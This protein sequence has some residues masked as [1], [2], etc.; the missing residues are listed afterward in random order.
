MN[1]KKYFAAREGIIL[2]ESKSA[3]QCIGIEG[4][5][6]MKTII[7]ILA[8][9]AFAQFSTPASGQSL[10]P[11][12]YKF[13]TVA[14]KSDTQH[15]KSESVAVD[16][17][18]NIYFADSKQQVICRVNPSGAVNII[19]GKT[20]TCGSSDGVG[21]EARFRYPHGIAIDT[22]GN[23]YVADS[24]N[25]TIRRI[26]PDGLVSTIAGLAGAAGS[27]DGAGMDARFRYPIGVA[28]D[29]LRNIYVADVYNGTIRKINA[30][31]VVSTIAG[32]AG[33]LGAADGRGNYPRFNLPISLAV[34]GSG[35][36]YVADMLNN[37][38]RKISWTGTVITWAGTMSYVSGYADGF[39]KGARFSHPCGIAVDKSGNIYVA[40]SGNNTIRRISPD[41]VVTTLAG[42]SGQRGCVD[43]TG[44]AAR[45][46]HPT[47]LA[48]DRLGNLYVTDR[49][50]GAIRE[51][52]APIS[53]NAALSLKTPVATNTSYLK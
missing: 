16:T 7:L 50:N 53:A 52:S 42:V 33:I 39:G 45:F 12:P 49:D 11:S 8:C 3:T 22:T 9:L 38:I 35:N 14:G 26:T 51:G 10:Y 5:F 30:R 48:L 46:W 37:A 47:A 27:S 4:D 23:I 28:V 13:T 6:K 44:A 15:F 40:D 20:G 41:R 34:D 25:N 24:G 36:V 1:T 31:G 2:F 32:Q 18:G 19:A 43:G 21:A 29:A 17:A